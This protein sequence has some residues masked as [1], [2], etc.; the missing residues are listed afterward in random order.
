MITPEGDTQLVSN[1]PT[2]GPNH[3]W[4]RPTPHAAYSTAPPAFPPHSSLET[5]GG[6]DGPA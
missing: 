3:S 5:A 6:W 4:I 1:L 2:A